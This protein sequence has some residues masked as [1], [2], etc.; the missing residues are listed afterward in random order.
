LSSLN[1]FPR[2]FPRLVTWYH[3]PG[4]SILSGRAMVKLYHTDFS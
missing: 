4:Y 3:A 1:I 2:S